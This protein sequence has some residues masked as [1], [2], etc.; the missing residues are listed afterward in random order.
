MKEEQVLLKKE[1]NADPMPVLIVDNPG[2]ANR[3]SMGGLT[4]QIYQDTILTIDPDAELIVTDPKMAL[5]GLFKRL[6]RNQYSYHEW[7]H[8]RPSTFRC[9]DEGHFFIPTI[10][11]CETTKK[12]LEEERFNHGIRFNSEP[13]RRKEGNVVQED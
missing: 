2:L 7:P 12:L 11:P 13:T 3:A 5:K 9:F 8:S 10:G 1:K 6:D 4:K